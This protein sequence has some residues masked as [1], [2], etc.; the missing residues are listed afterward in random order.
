[1][2]I[3]HVAA[4][5]AFYAVIG[6]WWIFGLVF[7]LRKQPPQAREAKRDRTSLLG[8]LLQA[9]AYFI[10]WYAPLQHRQFS[11]TTYGSPMLEWGMAV[12]TVAIAAASIW[13]VN[14]AVRRLGKQ[15]A[16]SARLVEGHML[17]QDGP[18]SLVRNPIY[19]GMFGLLVATGLAVGRGIPLLGAIVLF[20]LGTYI[21]V[22]REERLLRDA[23]GS[24]FEAY[25][26]K[27]PAVIP[28]IY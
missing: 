22:H 17:I 1:M 9:V 24:E 28:G 15:W 2:P 25:A 3:P 12:L 27:V 21:R 19:T 7:W 5:A 10:V 13:L 26:Q 16:L 14:A 8:L 18:Y 23:F 4:Q 11:A 20:A 6:C